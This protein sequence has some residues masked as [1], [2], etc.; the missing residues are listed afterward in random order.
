MPSST[1]SQYLLVVR[2]QDGS[3]VTYPLPLTENIDVTESADY[4]VIEATTGESP[5]ELI[6]KRDGEELLVEVSGDLILVLDGYFLAEG[7]Q[8]VPQAQ[9][10]SGS[11]AGEPLDLSTLDISG[12]KGP[13]GG[14]IWSAKSD[15]GGSYGAALGAVAFIGGTALLVNDAISDSPDNNTV[16]GKIV[17]GPV[18]EGNGLTVEVYQADGETLLGSA[19]VDPSGS[20]TLD[21]GDYTGAVVARVLDSSSAADYLDEAT[22]ENKDLNVELSA[23]A[24]IVEPNSTIEININAATTLAANLALSG[25]AGKPLTVD[26]VE[27]A[28]RDVA[29]L[30]SLED[31]HA[32]G[33]SPTN[34]GT[35]D[36][37]D[38][39]DAEEVYGLIL[40]AFSGADLNNGG[41][42]Q[43]TLENILSELGRDQDGRLTL[44]AKAQ[45]ELQL[46]AGLI[47]DGLNLPVSDDM[48]VLVDTV[49]PAFV[50]GASAESIGE[51]GGP[52]QVVYSA[53]ASDAATVTYSL[54]ETGDHALLSIN[55]QTGAVTLVGNP[56]HETQASYQF[57]VV[58]TDAAGNATEQTVS[59]DINDLDES[60]PVFTSAA[61]ATAIDENSGAGQV[62]YTATSTD[63]GDVSSGSITYS[64]ETS[65][66]PAL[67]I[68][69]AS[70]KVTLTVDP[71]FETQESYSFAVVATDEAG[72]SSDQAVTL[73]INDIADET[74]PTITSVAITS[75]TGAQNSILTAGDIVTVTVMMDEATV[76]DTTDGTPRIA[77]TIGE[78]TVY[79]N[80]ASGSGGNAL[81]FTY[82]VQAGE[83]DSNGIGIPANALDAN[84]ASLRDTTGNAAIL[85]HAA[86]ADN[87]DYR[88]DTEAPVASVVLE[89]ETVQLE[90]D[91]VTN[92][93]DYY[94]QLTALG[95]EG[96]FVVTWYGRDA[97]GDNSIFVQRFDTDGAA[98][99][100]PILLEP[101]G[102]ADGPDYNPQLTALGNEGA[103]VV[104]WYGR[105]AGGDFSI[106]VQRFD[107]DG[108]VVGTPTLLEPDGVANGYDNRPQLTALGS[109][110]AFAVT[111]YGQDAN[112]DYSVFV[113]RFDTDGAA[114][115][116]PILLEP[117][118]V[119]D[120]Q[121]QYPQL[122]ALGSEGA[123]VVTWYGEDANGDYSIFV[124]RFNAD[125]T[126]VGASNLIRSSDS[127]SVSS[128]ETGTAYL[129]HDSLTV[130][131]V[132]D[133]T[134]GADDLWNSVAITAANTSTTLAATGLSDGEYRVYTVDAA[135]NLSSAAETTITIDSTAPEFSSEATAAAIDENSGTG[136]VV[137]TADATDISVVNYSL[138]AVGDYTRFTIDETTGQVTLT[139]D[140]DFETQESYSFTVVATDAAGNSSEQAVTLGIN[141]IAESSLDTSIVVFDMVQGVSSEHS[142][143]NFQ[144]DV[145]YEIYVR[146]DSDGLSLSTAGN[147][148]G[149]WGTW[150]SPVNLGSDDKIIVVGDGS[151]I[152]AGNGVAVD[153]LWA[154]S[155]WVGWVGGNASA[156]GVSAPGDLYRGYSGN[157][158]TVQLWSNG[159]WASAP[160]GFTGSGY[161]LT[162]AILGDM[163]F[164]NMP[165][166]ILTSQ[167]LV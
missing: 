84:G 48:A 61:T 37:T 24:V 90:P 121:D 107:T 71:D 93:F 152:I 139:D 77:L 147:G 23:V 78:G 130:S 53:E 145:S 69:A 45:E 146:V 117:D 75:A 47:E 108:K 21:V 154:S 74:S 80:Y 12:D 116:T 115:G 9:F 52:D 25:V 3:V 54:K 65:S 157:W 89:P 31:L 120:G 161:R 63:D 149:T 102:V 156:V 29:E 162:G 62:I 50:S 150:N 151:P 98:V 36:V 85:S 113:Q 32:I 114:A 64:L 97:G 17:A 166:G 60:A 101:N 141:D 56:D 18:I 91:G 7:A 72:N 133:I 148:P 67:S 33:V 6:L 2:H 55:A 14:I 106:F 35:F 142:G 153:R 104:T 86:V 123:F 79:A 136:Q 128:T 13:D 81:L 140:P 26:A 34:G 16:T 132:E 59:L 124:Q 8:F 143:R 158:S 88:V 58:A 167:G 49:A 11:L 129:V 27:A 19:K 22:G 44:S 135:G 40:A 5:E 144:P 137:Y 51:N 41:D 99:G 119:A 68:D 39:L 15:D 83:A 125:G 105:D 138:K 73:S 155:S 109:N 111:W 160:G 10:G 43:A 38:G 66:D 46:G 1:S 127:I 110:G 159:G 42:S 165:S 82:A 164:T 100:T 20:F 4:A 87:A 118:G 126:P 76:V 95:S 70:G 163:Y 131:S 30:F 92:G 57:T 103:F 28:N 134:S 112:G 96:A 94:P 122:T